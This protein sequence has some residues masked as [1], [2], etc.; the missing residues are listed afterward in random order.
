VDGY[1]HSGIRRIERLRLRL[2]GALD[3]PVPVAGARRSLNDV[4][5]QLTSVSEGLAPL[6]DVDPVLQREIER[7]FADRDESYSLALVDI[8]DREAPRAA[9]VRADVRYSP[10]SVGKIVIAV[11]LFAELARRFPDDTDAR[12]RLLRER[13]IIAD[14]WIRSDHHKVVLFDVDTHD[15]GFRPIETGDRFSLFEWVDH[16]LSASANAAAS[17]VWKEVMLMHAFGDAYPP[18]PEEETAFFA[19]TP[20]LDL[21][22]MSVDVVNSPLRGFGVGERQWRQGSFFTREGKRRVPGV[23][24]YATPAAMLTFLWALERGAVIDEWSSLELKRLLYMTEKRIR[25][26]SSPALADAAVYF[27]SGSLYSCREEEGFTCGKYMGNVRNYMNSVAIVE[28]ADGRT[29]LVD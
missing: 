24:S 2:A 25:Y 19:D 27:K 18:S 14:E 9:M 11:G 28:Q 17:V 20:R 5:L 3:G 10:G 16:M 12:L 15:V 8:T 7:L 23:S 1:E 26:A 6:P 22:S 4:K 13:E 29:Y 21:Q